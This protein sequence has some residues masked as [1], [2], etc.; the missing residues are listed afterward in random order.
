MKILYGWVRELVDVTLTPEQAA[1]RLIGAGTEVASVTRLAPAG[2]RGVVVG[3]IRAIERDLGESHGHRLL[4]CRVSTGREELSVVSGAPNT[5]V[6]VRAAFAPP[7]ASLPGGRA[8]GMATIRGAPSQGML[9]S[10]REL[11]LGEEHESGLFELE[12]DARLG[13]D[14]VAHLGLEDSVLEIEITP[15]R[16]DCLSILGIARELSALTGAPLREPAVALKESNE[17]AADLARARIDAPDLCARFTARVITN[18]TVGPSPAWLAVRLRAVGLRPI[19]NVVDVTN[20]VLWELGHPLHAFDRDTVADHAIVVRRAA[21]GER[22]TTLDGQERTLTE[23]MLVIADPRRAIGL[24]GVMGGANTEVGPRTTRVLLEAAWFDPACIRRTSRALGLRTDAAYRFE[25]GAD[26]EA[27]PVAGARAAQLI[28]DLAGGSVARGLIDVYPAP[29]PRRRVSLRMSRVRRVLG[30]APR[31]AEAARILGG[32]GLPVTERGEELEVEVPGFRRDLVIEDDLV[33]EVIRVWGY[34]RIPST[35]PGGV[36][37]VVSQPRTLRQEAA[38]RQALAG[39]GL[40]EIVATSFTDPVTDEAL[41]GDG[42][43]EPLPLLNPLSEDASLMRRH[44]L[45]GVLAAIATNA[46]RQQPDVRIFEIGKTYGQHQA[47][48]VEPRWLAVAVTGARGPAAWYRAPEAADAYDAKGLAEHALAALGVTATEV[49]TPE[50]AAAFEPD[51]HGVLV[52]PDGRGVVEFGE[53]SATVRERFGIDA[54]VFA[55]LVGLDALLDHEPA[56][57]RHQPLP[58]Y[59]AVA[60]DLAFL[61]GAGQPVTAAEIESA[62]RAEAG[63]LLRDLTLFDVYR[64]PDGRRSLAWRLTFQAEDRTLTDDEVNTI[65]ARVAERATAGFSIALRSR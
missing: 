16:P 7:G 22:F 13:A 41:A 29:R 63:P 2:L 17:A 62:L 12:P 44:P 58:R 20:Y 8:I 28:A 14:L 40:S 33:E 31:V 30:I 39:A 36:T 5:R 32:L 56:P 6:G 25:R 1:E 64:F 11:G 37:G 27:L 57:S 38:L 59:P 49:A 19:S 54:P 50:P 4:L 61:I 43:L 46:R 53:V 21:R 10:E 9:C 18:V 45:A 24:A 35:V 42:P 60:R 47:D 23:A 15:N 3:E 52:T 51:L 34:D 48:I 55:A 26:V 65:Q